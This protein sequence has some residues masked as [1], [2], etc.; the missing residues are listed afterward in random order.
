MLVLK[1]IGNEIRYGKKAGSFIT[2]MIGIVFA[3]LLLRS[4]TFICIWL[5]FSMSEIV[6]KK[7]FLKEIPEV[8]A[9]LPMEQKARQ[10][11]ACI[12]AYVISLIYSV[13]VECWIGI[14]LLVFPN[15]AMIAEGCWYVD[16]AIIMA[17]FLE[18]AEK[19]MLGENSSYRKQEIKLFREFY[20]P[21]WFKWVNGTAIAIKGI[22]FL[23]V[24]IY[25]FWV[26]VNLENILASWK[27]K[28]MLGII[29][30]I[31]LIIHLIIMRYNRLLVDTGDYN[32]KAGEKDGE[33]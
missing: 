26:D 23:F 4:W 20:F 28:V 8:V 10:K 32:A 1:Q 9:F 2:S 16:A 13:Y 3:F 31:R 14:V 18:M 22:I 24:C 15:N 6:S 17:A 33:Q 29:L 30:A 19:T 12:K 11:Y 7:S 27:W 21:E 25:E 5:F